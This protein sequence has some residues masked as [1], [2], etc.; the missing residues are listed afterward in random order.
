MN[1]GIVGGADGPTSIYVASESG[2]FAIAAV[3]IICIAAV[4][5]IR[6]SKKRKR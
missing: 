2:P 1:I 3:A 4:L 6:R 5:I